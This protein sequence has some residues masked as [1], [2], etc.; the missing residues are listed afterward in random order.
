[1][2]KACVYVIDWIKTRRKL[3]K[4]DNVKK[5]LGEATLHTKFHK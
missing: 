3:L 2:Y 1:M 4:L 5:Q